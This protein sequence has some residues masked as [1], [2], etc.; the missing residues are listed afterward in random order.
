MDSTQFPTAPVTTQS[1]VD[2][3]N[4][5]LNYVGNSWWSRDAIDTRVVNNVRNY[6]GPPLGAAG[7]DRGRSWRL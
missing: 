2:A 6:T 3:Y 1:A 5:V 4:Q 7:A